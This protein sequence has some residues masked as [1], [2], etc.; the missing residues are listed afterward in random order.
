MDF[1]ELSS[2]ESSNAFGS[3]SVYSSTTQQIL[4]SQEALGDS[5]LHSLL[6]GQSIQS[7]N[8]F[9]FLFLGSPLSFSS[10]SLDIENGLLIGTELGYFS[11]SLS[12]SF[13]YS[14]V[15]GLGSNDNSY[16]TVVGNEL[17]V[18]TSLNKNTYSIRV[19]AEQG[20]YAYEQIF[21]L[22][23]IDT[24][25]T[26]GFF[27]GSL[28]F[29]TA[30]L[31][32]SLSGIQSENSAGDLAFLLSS[33]LENITGQESFGHL[34]FDGFIGLAGIN[35]AAYG[36]LKLSMVHSLGNIATQENLA[37]SLNVDYFGLSQPVTWNVDT[38][39]SVG[40]AAV[41]NVGLGVAKW[42]RVEGCCIFPTQQGSGEFISGPSYPGGCDVSNFQSSD[43]KCIGA[44]G[45]QRFIQNILATDV[46]DV[47][48]QLNGYNMRWQ[49]C[50]IQVYSNPAGPSNDSCNTLTE[51]PFSGYPECME[52]SLFSNIVVKISYSDRVYVAFQ[53]S[54]SGGLSVGGSS[55]VNSSS[56]GSSSFSYVGSGGL[57][58]GGSAF[59]ES[60]WEDLLEVEATAS[61]EITFIEA[62]QSVKQATTTLVGV[63]STISTFCGSCT[64]MP[65]IM[66]CYVN[67]DK[68]YMLS[69]FCLKNSVKL[70]K[71]FPLYYSSLLKSWTSNYQ[72]SGYG[73]SGRENWS[74]TFSWSC[75]SQRSGEETSPYWRYSMFLNRALSG[76]DFDTRVNV[77]FPPQEL[78]R[79]IN[80]LSVDLSFSLNTITG[81][82]DNSTVDVTDLVV[83]SDK[84]GVF[85]DANWA[86]DPWLEVR[87]SRSVN[88]PQFGTVDLSPLIP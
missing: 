15:S 26:L 81:Y 63:A 55:L 29:F 71:Y 21:T 41:W 37:N 3:S 64:A 17:V 60:S 35:D 74:F 16:F 14:L 11:V 87:V 84:V 85:K 78:C 40:V 10:Y 82:V 33:S 34:S 70:P 59:I 57:S 50:S 48:R 88:S 9:G 22:E 75:L 28:G 39:L 49:V 61:F 51:V 4:G 7:Q 6:Q 62:V 27:E 56:S 45:K 83:L 72:V 24:V 32:T 58:V 68:S 47:C 13:S 2:I 54:G 80:N 30:Y 44:T 31:S 76:R 1:V 86:A 69:R 36:S 38:V 23:A 65:S 52:I 77:T 5:I 79:I 42:Y 18:Y 8:D 66:Y 67:L 20:D 19:R 43:T 73:D 46:A 53:C 25:K 12:G